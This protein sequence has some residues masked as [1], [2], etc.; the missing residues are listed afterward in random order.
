MASEV[1]ADGAERRLI[2]RRATDTRKLVLDAVVAILNESGFGALTNAVIIARSGISSGAMMHHFPTR[3]SLLIAAVEYSY[4]TLTAFRQQQFDKLERGLPRFRA[5]IDVTWHA[6]NMPA[7][8]AVNEVRVGARSDA[9]MAAAFRPVFTHM[10]EDYGHVVSEL[11]RGAG[12]TPDEEMQGLWTATAMSMRALAI[13]R[14]TNADADIA[15]KALLALRVLRET[16]IVKQLGARAGQDPRI[17][18]KPP[19]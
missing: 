18:W 8:L 15:T 12:L 7:G 19:S 3:Q 9:Q 11:V 14:K 16:L 5:L 4:E 10:A 1:S 13:D 2:Q 6:A 17:A